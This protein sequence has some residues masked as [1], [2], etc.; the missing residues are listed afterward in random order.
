V[1][2]SFRWLASL[3][4]ASAIALAG[5]WIWA[6]FKRWRKKDPRELERLRRLDVNLR[7]RI[8]AGMIVDLI[9]SESGEG[10]T[11]LLLYKYPV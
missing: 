6:R 10:L 7:G 2:F 9:E 11:R 8:S 3:A 4:G 1:T 5:S